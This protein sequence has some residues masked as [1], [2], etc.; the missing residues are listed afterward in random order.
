MKQS[1]SIASI[2]YHSHNMGVNS[3]P[4]TR[5]GISVLKRFAKPKPAQGRPQAGA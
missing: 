5:A 3:T 4:E 1:V 2:M